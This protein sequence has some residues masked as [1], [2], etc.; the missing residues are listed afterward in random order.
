MKDA[1]LLPDDWEFGMVYKSQTKEACVRAAKKARTEGFKVEF[2]IV[3]DS[4]YKYAFSLVDPF[5]NLEHPD[6]EE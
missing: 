1:T 6:E 2:K 4:C 3:D 5:K